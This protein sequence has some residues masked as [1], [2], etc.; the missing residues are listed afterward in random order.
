[1][2]R[3]GAPRLR[4]PGPSQATHCVPLTGLLPPEEPPGKK[5]EH[6]RIGSQDQ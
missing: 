4:R 6:D 3:A 1:M 2:G 5:P